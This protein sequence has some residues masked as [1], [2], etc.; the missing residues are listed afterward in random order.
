MKHLLPILTA[1]LLGATTTASAAYYYDYYLDPPNTPPV[2][3]D[4]Q[5]Y[6]NQSDSFTY[7]T[8]DNEGNLLENPNVF[9]LNRES[10]WGNNITYDG[11]KN[12]FFRIEL[13]EENDQK[14]ALYLTDFVSSIYGNDPIYNSDS[15]AIFNDAYGTDEKG[16]TV[17]I[18]RGIVEYGYRTLTLENGKY[19]PGETKT[20]STVIEDPEGTIEIA[21]KDENGQEVTK[22]YRL[23]TENVHP[24]DTIKVN[25]W[26]EAVTRYEYNLGS[27]NPGDIIEV[28]MK[29]A[30]GGEVYSFSSFSEEDGE[31]VYTPF[32]K[33]A[34][35]D[36]VVSQG[37]FG[38]GGYRVAPIETDAML[39]NYYFVE[40]I[41]GVPNPNYHPDYTKFDPDKTAAAGKA[42]PL[43]QLIPTNGLAVAFGIY[44]LATGEAPDPKDK[45]GGA[46]GHPLPGGVQIA[47][48]AGLFGL[49][50]CY[51][52]RR[53]AIVG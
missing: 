25:A 22:T 3:N 44:G 18:K 15:N 36:D 17:L 32:D 52:R 53:K 24:K 27:F 47:L 26:N 16:D 1:A 40:S 42:M 31:S 30:M 50:F 12:N 38:D 51:I 33:N 20:F 34:P 45:I 8:R 37:G 41:A 48:I 43:S 14:V 49:G 13:S 7:G 28:Y 29:D 6:H 46:S 9:T 5:G 2:D 4:V 39:N 19:V 21:G 11:N 23:N 10:N 35:S